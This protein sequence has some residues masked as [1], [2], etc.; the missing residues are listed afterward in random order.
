ML[1]LKEGCGN[2]VKKYPEVERVDPTANSKGYDKVG[3]FTLRD[4]VDLMPQRGLQ[5]RLCACESN[6]I[7]L[8][9]AASMGKTFAMMLKGLQGVDAK[10]FTG[11]FISV[12]LQDSKKGSSIYR[13]GVEVWG[14]FGD[15]QFSS[16]DY[17]TFSW[18]QWNS[19]IQLIHSNFNADSPAEWEE[20]KDYAKKNQA[21]YIAIDEATEIKSFRMFAYWFS[22]NRDSSGMRPCMVLSFNPEHDHWT[23]QMLADAGY[24]G[25]D[26]YVRPEMN[27]VTRYFYI[28]G[29]DAAHIIWGNT[30]EE[31]AERADIKISAKEARAGITIHQ[32]VKS[33]TFFTGDAADNLKLISATGGQNIGNLHAVGKTQRSILYGA[34]FGPVENE[35]LKVTRSM[36]HNLFIN[37]QDDDRNM[38]GTLDVSGGTERS[39]GCPFV[40]WRGHTILSVSWFKGDPKELVDWIND[41][42]NEYDIPVENFAFDAT[43]LGYYLTGYTKGMP[44]TANQRAV[45]EFDELG[46][47]VTMEQ[48]FNLRSQLLGKMRVEF[49]K[50]EIACLVD[51]YA[52]M[53]YGNKGE[54]RAF[55]DA[56]FDQINIFVC[57]TRNKRIYYR[58]KDEYKAKFHCSPDLMDAIV[59]RARFDLDARP[60]KQPETEIDDYAYSEIYNTYDGRNVVYI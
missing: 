54:R 7:F 45:Q 42:L 58:S 53:P 29:D 22:R 20:F 30:A 40:A 47:P 52:P 55:I 12:R 13:D 1:R 17:P 11:R 14:S 60:K 51:K 43:G 31:V 2:T 10:G 59:L 18:P 15:C 34:Y 48:Y 9:G 16:S 32:I 25:D 6:L 41:R 19:N 49:E 28:K 56:L 4:K 23:T 21:S 27:G 44:V 50:G 37:P 33:F 8:A 26:W 3:G 35:E 5:E 24:L 46:N 57:T 38:Y 36:I 39:D